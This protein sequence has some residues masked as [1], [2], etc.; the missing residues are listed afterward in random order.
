[1][2][3]TLLP[4]SRSRSAS[5]LEDFAQCPFLHFAKR[6]LRL[7]RPEAVA[8]LDRR[9][10]GKIAHDVLYRLF[11]T[12]AGRDGVPSPADVSPVLE[13]VFTEATAG[14]DPGVS[15]GLEG[16]RVR[17]DLEGWL[18]SLVDRERARLGA[19]PYRPRLFEVSFGRPPHDLVVPGEGD[20]E[21]RLTGRMDRIDVAPDGGAVVIDYKLGR[22]FGGRSRTEVEEGAHLQLPVYLLALE[23]S[24]GFRPR[25]AWLYPVRDGV[26]SGFAHA[27][28][29]FADKSFKLSEEELSALLERTRGFVVEYDARIR[30]GEIEVRP[31]DPDRCLRCDFA[32]LCRYEA[33]MSEDGE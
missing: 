24:F 30:G 32:D 19:T 9:L 23:R 21:V 18:R 5:A 31:R 25:G 8:G 13:E 15:D 17:S 1:V 16:Q 20:A 29:P 14:L 3:P 12:A 6:A 11:S 27:E 26:T 2:D 33:W 22:G 4:E 10:I 7:S 28:G